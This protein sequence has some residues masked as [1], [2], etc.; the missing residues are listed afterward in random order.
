ML[1]KVSFDGEPP[2]V[3]WV[4][5][6]I[7]AKG[8]LTILAGEGGQGKSWLA[9]ALAKGVTEG[10]TV[11]GIPC[12]EG[13]AMYIDAENGYLEMFRRVRA[14]GVP[15]S[16]GVYM[17]DGF[18]LERNQA[19]LA[20]YLA[21]ERP[22]LL[23]LDGLRTLWPDGDENDS[24]RVTGVLDPLRELLREYEVGCLL[25]HHLSKLGRY[26]GST[27]IQASP[28]ILVNMYKKDGTNIRYLKWEKCRVSS[29]P[30]TNHEFKIVNGPM[31]G[32]MLDAAFRP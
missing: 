4:C 12:Q 22:A 32:V 31:G 23:V 6:G 16:C 13:G 5:D 11:A 10:R 14:L 2:P 27:A 20:H 17:A 7:C 25:L 1:R 15:K 30:P 18:N 28:E 24:A 26:R 9:L 21:V 8:C 3:P 19:G 29:M